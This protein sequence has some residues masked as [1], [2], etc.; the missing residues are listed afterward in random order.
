MNI[1]GRAVRVLGLACFLALGSGQV[2]G[3]SLPVEVSSGVVPAKDAPQ[4]TV[5]RSLFAEPERVRISV[6]LTPFHRT[7]IEDQQG[8]LTIKP[9]AD[10]P[11]AHV[12]RARL[13]RINHFYVHGWHLE[14]VPTVWD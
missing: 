12:L 11:I 2:F 9:I 7:T 5:S 6:Q 1:K 10:R 14:S 4:R 8:R 3:T 13:D